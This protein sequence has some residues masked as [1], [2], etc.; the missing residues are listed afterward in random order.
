MLTTSKFPRHEKWLR[1]RMQNR[2]V[3]PSSHSKK[4]KKH[5]GWVHL[6]TKEKG[7]AAVHVANHALNNDTSQAARLV[8]QWPGDISS[9]NRFGSH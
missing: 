2:D 6:Q 4:Q 8:S 3:Q 9:S 5:A 1:M 7:L